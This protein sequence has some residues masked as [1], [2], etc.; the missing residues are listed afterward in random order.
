LHSQQSR[1]QIST[2]NLGDWSLEINGEGS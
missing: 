2:D 1:K